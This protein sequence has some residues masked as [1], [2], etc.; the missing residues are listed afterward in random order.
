MFWRLICVNSQSVIFYSFFHSGLWG[1]WCLSPAVYDE[2]RVHPG[3]VASPSQ[4]NTQ[5]HTGQTTKHTH[6]HTPKGNLEGPMNL[7][8]MSLDCGRKP[9][10]P[11]RTHACMGRTCKLHA[12]RPW[13]GIEPR[14]FLLQ[15]SNFPLSAAVFMVLCS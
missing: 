13:P 4:S 2:R 11:V 1:S 5:T 6:I 12:E 14:T 15:G 7:A 3:R 10:Y 9:E 8:G